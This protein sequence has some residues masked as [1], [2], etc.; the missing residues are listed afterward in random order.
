MDKVG[1][2]TLKVESAALWLRRRYRGHLSA[3]WLYRIKV[4]AELV[5]ANVHIVHGE[6]LFELK[7]MLASHSLKHRQLCRHFLAIIHE[8][9]SLAL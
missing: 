3:E 6:A 7:T 5:W 9:R 2:A 1:G 4:R 8:K